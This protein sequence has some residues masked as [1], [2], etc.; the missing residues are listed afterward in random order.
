MTL[1]IHED[2]DAD[3]HDSMRD[4]SQVIFVILTSSQS[5]VFW[6]LA[7]VPTNIGWFVD[8]TPFLL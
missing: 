4:E 7:F 3:A 8:Y 5:Q 2:L 6:C 1:C